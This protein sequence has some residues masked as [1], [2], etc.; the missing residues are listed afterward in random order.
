[1]KTIEA[2]E[3]NQEKITI[4]YKENG[5]LKNVITSFSGLTT[6]E[7][8]MM[9]DSS[10]VV[11]D[12]LLETETFKSVLAQIT[13][14]QSL[15]EERVLIYN[16]ENFNIVFVNVSS[17]RKRP[18]GTSEYDTYLSIKDWCVSKINM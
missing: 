7:Q 13:P 12:R 9:L 3:L 17:F 6:E 18:A 8:Q 5:Q 15:S 14:E 16:N 11:S 1:M 2:F 10:I 4:I